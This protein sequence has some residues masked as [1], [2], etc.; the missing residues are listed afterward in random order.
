MRIRATELASK[1]IALVCELHHLEQMV[2]RFAVLETISILILLK[3]RNYK[4]TENEVN[5]FYFVSVLLLLLLLYFDCFF[6]LFIP[7]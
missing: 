1:L 5:G 3:S 4:S 2:Q 6:L 7:Y